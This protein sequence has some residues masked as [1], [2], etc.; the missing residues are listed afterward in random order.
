MYL[1]LINF[2]YK[3][4][5]DARLAYAIRDMIVSD[6]WPLPK[7]MHPRGFCMRVTVRSLCHDS[8]LVLDGGISVPFPMGTIAVLETHPEDS[9]RNIVLE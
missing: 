7:N 8:G 3:I 9:L 5:E 1:N 4:S 6:T 2:Q